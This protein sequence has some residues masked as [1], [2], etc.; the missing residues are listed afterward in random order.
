MIGDVLGAN[1]ILHL[2]ERS[3]RA[4]PGST[5]ELDY[6]N[7]IGIFTAHL[8]YGGATVSTEGWKRRLHV[9]VDRLAS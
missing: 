6:Q 7:F 3:L 9:E 5:P 1:F 8:E 2:I 4:M